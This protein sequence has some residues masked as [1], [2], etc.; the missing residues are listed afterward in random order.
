LSPRLRAGLATLLVGAAAYTGLF[1]LLT[2]EDRRENAQLIELHTEALLRAPSA[3][4]EPDGGDAAAVS[5]WK[6]AA[7]L[8]RDRET[9]ERRANKVRYLA[10]GLFGAF[11]VQSAVTA[12]LLVR[13]SRRPA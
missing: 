11:A 8:R 10:V 12:A 13:S 6:R 4:P 2:A 9:Y 5:R 7:E 3:G 1:L